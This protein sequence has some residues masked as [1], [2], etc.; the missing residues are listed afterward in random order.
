[1]TSEKQEQKFYAGGNLLHPIRSTTQIRVVIRHQYGISALVSQT[2][3]RGKILVAS[4]NVGCF[5][6]LP[7]QYRRILITIY[8]FVYAALPAE[9]AYLSKAKSGAPKD[10]IV[11]NHLNVALL[12]VF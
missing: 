1:M 2:S 10:N 7:I 4:Q 9:N 5:L 8:Y 11:Q 3:F 6:S 12:N